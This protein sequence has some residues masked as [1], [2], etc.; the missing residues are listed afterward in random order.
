MKSTEIKTNV[1]YLIDKFSKEEFIY[2]LLIAYGISKTSV[3]RLKKGDY[4]FAKSCRKERGFSMLTRSKVS[5]CILTL[6][7]S[8]VFS[9]YLANLI[10]CKLK[11]CIK[12]S[13]YRLS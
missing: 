11:T 8:F 10:D 9:V 5:A 7:L 13:Y 1:Q 4:N 6:L 12:H 2:D 3:P